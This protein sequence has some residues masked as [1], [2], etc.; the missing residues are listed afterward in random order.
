MFRRF[1]SAI[2]GIVLIYAI[3]NV[4]ADKFITGK[5]TYIGSSSIDK[6]SKVEI[7][8]RDVS[9]M[10]VPSKLIASTTISDAKIFPISYQLKYN[11]SDIKPHQTYAI[12]VAI[13]DSDNKLLFV[14]N[15]QAKVEFTDS[16]S[17]MVNIAVIRNEGSSS[18]SEIKHKDKKICA[19]L[20]CPIRRKI[21]P[22]GYQKKDGCETCRCNDPCNPSGKP[23]LCGPHKRCFVEKKSDGTFGTRCDTV[24][25]K[26]DEK[27]HSKTDCSLP[28]VV[29]RC[30]AD[31]L[32]FYYNSTTK[33]CESFIYGG[34]GGNRNRFRTKTACETIC[35]A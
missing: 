2:I 14:N 31:F 27:I 20:K 29:G 10:D 33:T 34:C 19:P 23:I 6:N 8:L 15:V 13:T 26:E 21:C 11:P 35:K 25:S 9:L 30:K 7:S 1:Y 28:K 16:T 5:I 22:Y 32:N 18:T 4:V 3:E 12:S 24:P 17:P